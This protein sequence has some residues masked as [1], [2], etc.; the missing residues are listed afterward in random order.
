MATGIDRTKSIRFRA[1]IRYWDETKQ[2]GLAVAD[3]PA[4]LVEA[5]GGRR[6]RRVS[7][8][9]N[10]QPFVGSTMLVKGGGFCVGVTKD[11][12]RAAGV[13]VGDSVTVGLEPGAKA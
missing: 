10:G 9:L 3:V 1:R 6:Q 5:L 8:T 13:A 7:G 11:A 12:M 4:R 2:A